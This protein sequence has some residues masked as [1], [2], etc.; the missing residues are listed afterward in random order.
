MTYSVYC[1]FYYGTSGDGYVGYDG[2]P[3]NSLDH[4]M[5]FSDKESAERE[6]TRLQKIWKSKLYVE[7][8]SL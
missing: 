6:L 2:E 1:I 7:E 3:C 5:T 8:V 4:A